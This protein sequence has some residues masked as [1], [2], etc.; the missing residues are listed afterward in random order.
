MRVDI[1]L[2]IAKI[3]ASGMM[4]YMLYDYYLK[5]LHIDT[6]LIQMIYF[7]LVQI[8]KCGLVGPQNAGLY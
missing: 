5:M 2:K 1:L 7:K 8:S 4:S 6:N 3:R